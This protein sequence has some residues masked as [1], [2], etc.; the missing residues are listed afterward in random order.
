MARIQLIGKDKA[1]DSRQGMRLVN[2]AR[3]CS[4]VEMRVTEREAGSIPYLSSKGLYASLKCNA[5]RERER[6]Y[7]H[8]VL[9]LGCMTFQQ[10]S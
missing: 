7:M 6:D 9:D 4:C 10:G 1:S 3:R 8:A 5:E 2:A